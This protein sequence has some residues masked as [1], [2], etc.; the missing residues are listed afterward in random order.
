MTRS[1]RRRER[2]AATAELAMVLP[3]LVAVTIGLVWLLAVGAAQVRTVDAARET[4]RAVARGDSATAAVA[5]GERV[6]PAG[7]PGQRPRR[8]RPGRR[9]RRGPGG[10]AGRA[11]RAAARGHGL[12]RGG[13]RRRRSRREPAQRARRGDAVRGRLPRRCCCCSAPRSAWWRRWCARTGSP[14]PRPTWP[15]WLRPARSGAGDPCAAGADVAAANGAR[16]ASCAVAG[17]DVTVR[18]TVTGPRWLG[19]AGDL[20][21]EARAGPG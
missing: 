20:T 21:A 9:R 14:S 1:A 13:R 8:R 4:A 12:G 16:L 17:R 10:R 2:G 15:R 19:Q 18:V 6:A 7:Q 3:L 11:V 5:R